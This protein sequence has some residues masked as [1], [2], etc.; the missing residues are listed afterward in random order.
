MIAPFCQG[1]SGRKE[2]KRAVIAL[3]ATLISPWSLA[4]ESPQRSDQSHLP[5]GIKTDWEAA[6]R[7]SQLFPSNTAIGIELLEAE[8]GMMRQN[9]P[10][11]LAYVAPIKVTLTGTSNSYCFLVVASKE[12]PKRQTISSSLASDACK[13]WRLLSQQDVNGDGFADF[14]FEETLPSNRYD[15]LVT[16]PKV[17]VSD[18]TTQSYCFSEKGSSSV[19]PL[20]GEDDIRKKLSEL[21][22]HCPSK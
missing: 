21:A 14:V 6:V 10:P 11:S 20:S 12:P 1:R 3:I 17:F 16:E 5:T 9:L 4:M 19:N 8:A 2:F 7:Q 18:N 15:V 22:L 13:E